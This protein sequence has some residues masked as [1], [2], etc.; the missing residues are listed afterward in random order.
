MSIPAPKDTII[1][2]LTDLGLGQNEAKLYEILVAT[3]DATIPLL[4]KTSPFSRPMLYY[5]LQSLEQYELVEAKQVGKKTVYNAAQPER[6]EE[7]ITDQEKSLRRQREQ[8]KTIIGDLRSAYNLAH[9]KP[10][11]KFYEG[12]D[13]V[14]Q[15]YEELLELNE[16]IESIEDKG[17]MAQFIPDYYPTFIKKRVERKIFNRVVVPTTNQI[18]T[19]SAPELRETRTIP[20]EDFP[21]SMDIKISGSAVLLTTLKEGQAMAVR[22]VHPLIAENYKLIFNFFWHHAVRREAAAG[23]P[24]DVPPRTSG[25]TVFKS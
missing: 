13:G 1:T 3:P 23:L 5:I 7:F 15:A 18:N 2:T 8:L 12:K 10:G 24:A 21:F 25:A 9:N 17:E 16:P 11:V 6:L 22:I 4:Q 19:T 14:I 20:V